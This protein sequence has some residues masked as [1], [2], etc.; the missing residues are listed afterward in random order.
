MDFSTAKELLLLH[1]FSHPD[2]NHPKMER[3]FLGS[4][5]P[6]RGLNEDNFH[7]VMHAIIAL[8]QH[9]QQQN[10]VDKEVISALWAICE[11]GRAWGVHPQGMLRRNNLITDED[12]ARLEQW[13][14]TISY[15][16]LVLLDGGDLEIALG[17][18]DQRFG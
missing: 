4:L 9:L 17:P 5:R 11:L 2:I 8:A 1:S 18:Y 3:G 16:V 6:Y 13:I 7:E 10:Q 12:V 15:A 14:E